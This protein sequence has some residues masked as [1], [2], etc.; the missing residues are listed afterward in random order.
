MGT[1][2]V[3]VWKAA[4]TISRTISIPIMFAP[5]L[6]HAKTMRNSRVRLEVV[7]LRLEAVVGI[8]AFA[9][10]TVHVRNAS[11]VAVTNAR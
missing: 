6:D 9:L 1:T 8:T 11:A 2:Y 4:P 10:K 3:R 7:V 5:S